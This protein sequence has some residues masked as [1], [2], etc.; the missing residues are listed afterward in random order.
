MQVHAQEVGALRQQLQT[1]QSQ[2][3]QALAA[4]GAQQAQ[5]EERQQQVHS[6]QGELDAARQELASLRQAAAG[7]A[8]ERSEWQRVRSQLAEAAAARDTLQVGLC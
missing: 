1:L 4:A 5:G 2:Q 3:R 8:L 6:L 7:S